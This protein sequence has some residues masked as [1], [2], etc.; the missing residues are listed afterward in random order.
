MTLDEAWWARVVG[1]RGGSLH[2][3]RADEQ[4]V[5]LPRAS[6][7]RVIVDAAC[8]KA[9]R[10]AVD[11]YMS[12]QGVAAS[13][14]A[15]GASALLSLRKGGWKVSSEDL[16]L[17]EY[18]SDV[19]STEVK[20]SVA[21]GPKRPNRKPIVRCYAGSELV[22]V[23][24]MGPDPHTAALVEN[25]YEWLEKFT[26][27]CF[28]DIAT[29]TV[30]HKGDFEGSP[31][32]LLAPFNIGGAPMMELADIPVGLTKE[33][34]ERFDTQNSVADGPWW[35]QMKARLQDA[36]V[37]RYA[38][39]AN[40]FDSDEQL[41]SLQTS[42]W[43][44]DWSPWNMGKLRNGQLMIWD[45]ERATAGVPSGFDLL[46]LHYQYGDG[47]E[48]ARPGLDELGLTRENQRP[49]MVA[50]LLE[51]TARHYEAGVLGG[52]RQQLVDAEFVKLGLGSSSEV[53]T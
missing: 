20:L 5:L 28:G 6:E 37:R 51:L 44:G 50:Y 29:P 49:L 13:G 4:Y 8:S 34:N 30:I 14:L 16:T 24:K 3:S 2:S 7:P 11:R 39:I 22:G 10:D 31:L 1:G 41:M 27:H 21:V 42:A 18:L 12:K 48:A 43:H 38:E 47:L 9:M 36:E 52:E 25:E 33:L 45:W 32:L 19:L 35:G 23:A 53:G 15:F 46:H 26:D 17:R 40:D